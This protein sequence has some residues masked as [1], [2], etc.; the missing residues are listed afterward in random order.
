[1]RKAHDLIGRRF[2]RLFVLERYPENTKGGRAQW[3]CKCDCGAK[4]IVSGPNLLNGS[5][6]S[7]GCLA[8]ETKPQYV[9]GL[10]HTR[11][12]YIWR[13]MKERCYI[14]HYKAYKNYGARG[15]VMCDEWRDNF[16]AFYNWS[17]EHGYEEN[18]S[19]D[20]ID[21]N[22]NYCPENCR[23][24][25]CSTQ[26][27]N[28]RNNVHITIN[29]KTK[30]LKDWCNIYH[31]SIQTVFARVKRGMSYIEALEAPINFRKSN[32]AKN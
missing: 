28:K 25:T 8:R 32:R 4:K 1:M 27:R 24:V 7:C 26:N 10:S 14:P 22:G 11:L 17:M 15:I 23:W 31:I 13:S 20:R 29:G 16:L 21:T 3:I 18:L 12:H 6:K 2:G 5:T 19:I 30:V 9:H